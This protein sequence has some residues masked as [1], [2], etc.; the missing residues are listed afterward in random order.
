MGSSFHGVCNGTNLIN[1]QQK[2]LLEFKPAYAVEVSNVERAKS[3]CEM[4][5]RPFRSI[6][7]SFRV[8]KMGLHPTVYDGRVS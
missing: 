5:M 8:F 1:S 4:G 3:G 2:Y 6:V 7:R